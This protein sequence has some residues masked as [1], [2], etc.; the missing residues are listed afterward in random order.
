MS[1]RKA[2][3]AG[4]GMQKAG[5]AFERKTTV[6][7]NFDFFLEKASWGPCERPGLSP[8]KR[9]PVVYLRFYSPGQQVLNGFFVFLFFFW[10]HTLMGVHAVIGS[11]DSLRIAPSVKESLTV[12]ATR[13]L[14]NRWMTT[15][16]IYLHPPHQK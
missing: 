8:I 13:R 2:V 15:S 5:E 3:H 11:I 10:N 14:I 12:G 16:S 1:V 7:I 6:T 9:H 4:A